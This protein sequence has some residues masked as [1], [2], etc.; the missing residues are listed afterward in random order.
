MHYCIAVANGIIQEIYVSYI[1]AMLID[2][3]AGIGQGGIDICPRTPGKIVENDNFRNIRLNQG[4]DDVAPD[5][6]GPS[7]D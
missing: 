4:F 1:P 7:N 2:S 3:A 5:E 6:P